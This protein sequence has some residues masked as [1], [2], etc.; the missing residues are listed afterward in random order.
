MAV[1]PANMLIFLLIIIPA[2]LFA[3]IGV[4]EL[5]GEIGGLFFYEPATGTVIIARG[6][7]EVRF[8]VGGSFMLLNSTDFISGIKPAVYS[9]GTIMVPDQTADSVRDFFAELDNPSILKVGAIVIDPGHGGSNAPGAARTEIDGVK[10]N[11]IE[12]DITL[13][14]GKQLFA[15]LQ[16]RYPNKK[17]VMTRS[18]DVDVSLEQRSNI[19]NQL[20]LPDNEAVI[21]VSVHVD[22]AIS[23][24]AKG[25]S[26]HY[27]PSEREREFLTEDKVPE[28][29]K[30]ILPI[31]NDMLDQEV[32]IESVLLAKRIIGEL[33]KKVGDVSP[34]R[35]MKEADFSVVR[36]SLMPA[37]LVETGFLSNLEEARRLLDDNYLMKLSEAIYNGIRL[38]VEDYEKSNGFTE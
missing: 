8:M 29:Q 22:G 15:M 10:I 5:S 1:K 7:D 2:C 23:S 16:R 4:N 27:F 33:E 35:G 26:V 25:F 37:V 6:L 31:L 38:F 30:D 28:D 36:R 17:I 20:G 3:D 18:T 19:A 12:K 11:I 32:H 21:F 24:K 14:I 9:G 34:S 13:K